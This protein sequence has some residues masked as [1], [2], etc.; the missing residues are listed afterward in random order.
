MNRQ[1]QSP[2][3]L[4]S[5]FLRTLIVL[6]LLI[7][8]IILIYEGIHQGI[9]HQEFVTGPRSKGPGIAAHGS[10]AVLIGIGMTTLGIFFIY[11]AVKIFKEKDKNGQEK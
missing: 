1:N 7:P 8:G 3:P 2:H 5:I 10:R 6:V 4:L 11:G 9:I